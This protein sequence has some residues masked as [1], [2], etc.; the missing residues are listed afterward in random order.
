MKYKNL[1]MLA[2][3]FSLLTTS[4]VYAQETQP[5]IAKV[6]SRSI[7]QA[8]IQ[9]R[10]IPTGTIVKIRME[11]SLNTQSAHD[12]APFTSTLMQDI[13]IGQ[14]VILPAGSV[15]RG[16]V[17]FIQKTRRISR[18]A[19]MVLAFD[20]VVTPVGKQLPLIAAVS[21]SQNISKDGG[22][23]AEGSYYTEVSSHFDHNVEFV[24]NATD[25]GIKI[26]KTFWRGYPVFVTTPLAAA[27]GFCVGSCDFLGRSIISLFKKG[28]DVIVKPGQIMEIT[29][30]Q[31]LD[32]PLN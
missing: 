27:G 19:E 24:K 32:V 9:S 30:K 12:G 5:E 21:N 18:G 3:S 2:L 25:S 7:I 16:T 11:N 22:I 8:D 31:P 10:R 28:N 6:P 1:A 15:I 4:S 14:K 23:K 20:H 29:L 17:S 13:K 26:G